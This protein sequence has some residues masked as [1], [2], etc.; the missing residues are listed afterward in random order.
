MLTP[1][2]PSTSHPFSLPPS[3]EKPSQN[4]I[5]HLTRQLRDK[6]YKLVSVEEQLKKAE[7]DHFYTVKKLE[8]M[9]L[10]KV[11]EVERFKKGRDEEVARLKIEVVEKE[12]ALAAVLGRES[13]VRKKERWAEWERLLSIIKSLQ[14][15]KKWRRRS[16]LKTDVG[17]ENSELKSYLKED[18]SNFEVESVIAGQSQNER[19]PKAEKRDVQ[20]KLS[21]ITISQPNQTSIEKREAGHIKNISLYAAPKQPLA[22]NGKHRSNWSENHNNLELYPFDSHKKEFSIQKKKQNDSFSHLLSKSPAVTKTEIKNIFYDPL[23]SN[24]S[25]HWKWE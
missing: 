16:H 19:T 3:H 11:A 25:E 13:V 20:T 15:K 17:W 12:K 1:T 24:D 22:I 4:I 5:D 7:V 8:K 2:K 18:F 21:F 23:G 14:S 10:D 9:Y 6:E